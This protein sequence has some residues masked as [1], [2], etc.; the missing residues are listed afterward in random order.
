MLIGNSDGIGLATRGDCLRLGGISSVFPE[1]NRQSP[2]QPTYRVADVG[3]GG[4]NLM[5]ELVMKVHWISA[6]TSW[7]SVNSWMLG[8]SCEASH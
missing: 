5:D 7:G 1:A 3:E 4:T 2:A 8:P 6:S